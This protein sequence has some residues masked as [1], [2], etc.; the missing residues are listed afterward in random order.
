MEKFKQKKGYV[1]THFENKLE[2]LTS[3][4]QLYNDFEDHCR[5]KFK[6]EGNIEEMI[7][8]SDYVTNML[9][10]RQR[11]VDKLKSLQDEQLAKMM[12]Q[13]K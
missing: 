7:Q 10:K 11:R 3:K 9:A 8:E 1:R 5:K 2:S 6:L 12:N 4:I 13:L